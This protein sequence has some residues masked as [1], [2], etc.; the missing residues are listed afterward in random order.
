MDETPYN[1]SWLDPDSPLKGS[2]E[3]T[4][5]K[6]AQTRRIAR[7][8]KIPTK[9][10]EKLKT[11]ETTDKPIQKIY[12]FQISINRKMHAIYWSSI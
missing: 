10:K 8:R 7:Y 5:P 1:R 12:K 9:Y 6:R 4:I 11:P 2:H 3:L